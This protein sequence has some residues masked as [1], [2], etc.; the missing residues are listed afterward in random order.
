MTVG[1]VG[2]GPDLRVPRRATLLL[3]DRRDT[4]PLH[5]WRDTDAYVL[6]GDPGAGKSESL[7][8]E[9]LA[10]AGVYRSARDFIAL[11]VE[12]ASV[13]KT[14]FIDGLD[15]MRAG[16]ADG[17]VP[18]DAIRARLDALGRPRFRLSCRE[19]DWRA[20]TDLAALAQ[21]APGGA[22]Q[23]LHLEP[24][25]RE[26]QRQVLEARASEVPDA[27]AFF[28]R[29]D[30]HGLANLFGNPL[31]L[32]LTIRAVAAQGGWPG[33]RRSIYDL[34]CRELA[35]ERS[36]AHLDV[37]P[38]APGAIDRL[39]DDAGLLCAVLLLS[40]KASLTRAQNT[41][42]SSVAWHL[43][44]A[45][46]SLHDAGATLASN[47]FLTT[48]TSG[49]SAPRHRSIA[50]YLA[51]KAIARQL[52]QGLPLG[53]VLALMQGGD[54][55][56]VEPLRGLLGWLTVHEV[57]DRQRLIRLD[58]LGVVLNGDV[59]AFSTTDKRVLLEALRD[60]ARRNPWFRNGQWVS[61]PFAP[62]ASTDM[63]DAL[64][65]VLTDHSAD[66]SH[67]ALVECVLDALNH[68]K[69]MPQL[70]PLLEAWVEDASAKF[71]NRIGALSAWK[72][73]TDFD[74]I[75]AREWLDQLHQGRMPDLNCQL[76][77]ELLFDLYPEHIG[78]SEVLRYWPRPGTVG[79]NTVV[80]D[81]WYRGL[82]A[83]TR[84]SNFALLADAWL[85][86]Q[87]PAHRIHQEGERSR[88]RSAILANALEQS[89]DQVPDEKLYA[90]LGIG[91]DTH[92]FSKLDGQRG[93]ERIAKWLSDRPRRLKAVVALGWRATLPDEKS[94]RRYF[95][96][97]EHR[98]HGAGLPRDW[99]HWLLQQATDAPNGELA[100][101]C[102]SR[103]AHAAI[104][105]PAGF[106]VP[107][108]EQIEAWVDINIERW[109]QAREW[110]LKNW[111]SALEDNWQSDRHR[112]QRKHEAETLAG[113]D[114]RRQALAPHVD[115]IL[116][117]TAPAYV[118]HQLAG[119]YEGRFYDVVG[120]TPELRLQD[121]LVADEGTARAAIS[122]LG[123]VLERSD[124]PSA[125]EVLSL[126][127]KGKYHLLR[128][129][130]LLA[131][132][133]AHEREPGVVDAWPEPLLATLV[134]FWLTDGMGETPGW[135]KKAVE[136]RPAVV[137]PQLVR[138]AL[139]RLRRKG[140]MFVTGLRALA[141]EAG[142]A[143]LARLV[144]PPLIEGFPQRASEAARR[145]LNSS[146]LAALHLLDDDIASRLVRR[147]IDHPSTDSS[148]RICWLVADLPHRAEAAQRL[149]D[150]VGKNERRTVVLG[151]ALHEQGS[152]SRA[153][154]RVQ[155]VTLARLIELLAP[156]TQPVRPW[157]AHLVS[158]AHERG[159][160][161]RTL[162]N[163]LASDP[164]SAAT[165]E[166]KRLID[167][168]RL[169]SW[170][171]HLRYSML[172]Q[173]GVAREAHYVH[174][175]P[176]AAALTLAN[177]SPANR[178]D[179]MA[180]TLDHLSDIQRHLR[181]ADTFEL[182]LFWRKGG[183][184]VMSP[185]DENDCRDLLLAKLR[186]RLALLGVHVV[187]ERRAADD[188]RADL[189]VE[190]MAAGRPLAV[191]VE[192][193]KENSDNLWLAWRDQ[194]QALYSN[195][196]AADGHGIYLVLWFNHMPRSSPEGEKPT[197]A[198]DLER[199]LRERIPA[200]ERARLVVQV[201][202]LSLPA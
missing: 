172:S 201:I 163:L 99:L 110:L 12:P 171:E 77:G 164:H 200:S 5:E 116:M 122:N 117:G 192:I 143:V 27:Q 23:E 13:G 84:S 47:V 181:G 108:M 157:G 161:V 137:A 94:G 150:A 107:T 155:A 182:R 93:G 55:G 56:I 135:Y 66:D 20:Q 186:P 119:A 199:L 81:F 193:K 91:I 59:A 63:A 90:W 22:V 160:T 148:Q 129:P 74:A 30:E 34:A 67:Q 120:D 202:D 73:C 8:S 105:P 88:L 187:P 85:Q 57:H 50:E 2:I 60:E 162:I 61:Y 62:L 177:Y 147:K 65:Q 136:S 40:G 198:E 25:S 152:L 132:R 156:I 183:D 159:D 174:P 76:A 70:R 14:L 180:L 9:A 165:G 38:L 169:G 26:E 39:L 44:P 130:A 49:E 142:H 151:I 112:R 21:V 41:S 170:R 196:P 80:P 109:P 124:L 128:P 144:L 175:S 75:K 190:F 29:A 69:P 54:G 111:S 113:K 146:L 95:W 138:H 134:A 37:K 52:Q 31:L 178:A 28:D 43:L 106:D 10:S 72:R 149:V 158:P 33:S 51:G 97:S 194:L 36:Q 42:I 71:R 1:R 46:L 125:D 114:A 83:Q 189:R 68:G 19:H 127:S 86:L 100:E 153:L 168:P 92:G 17:R 18:L 45:E 133:L 115:A 96:E 184:G 102:F 87:P 48:S 82:I 173:Q 98:L 141:H 176:Q 89:G 78:A 79:T 104:D 166:M 15:E 24:L 58:P 154:K 3:A 121:F 53:R 191:P 7:R 131:A 4:R 6:L 32:D 64:M 126:D 11:G 139:P 118:L 103:V 197:A 16:G 140:Q 195:D 145:E 188:K 179:L 167:L 123:R 101:Y 35:T 185:I